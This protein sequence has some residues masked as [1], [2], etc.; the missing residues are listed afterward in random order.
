MRSRN[1]VPT[2]SGKKFNENNAY[3]LLQ[4]ISFPRLAG[5]SG[6]KKVR[7]I[8]TEELKQIGFKPAF[9]RFKCQ[10]F[11]N[12]QSAL[13]VISPYYKRYNCDVVGLSGNTPSEGISGN[14]AVINYFSHPV[15]KSIKDSI[16]FIFSPN[17]DLFGLMKRYKIK[18]YVR[19]S[20]PS[21]KP[22]VFTTREPHQ[23]IFGKIPAVSISYEDAI[24]IIHKGASKIRITSRQKMFRAD[25]SNISV[26]VKGSDIP[27]ERIIVFGHYDSVFNSCAAQDNGG[28]TVCVVELARYFKQHQPL[29]TITFILFGAEEMGLL[30]SFY[31]ADK[32]TGKDLSTIKLAINIDNVGPVFGDN[33]AVICGNESMQNYVQALAREIGLPMHISQ[34]AFSS[35]NIPLNERGIPSISLGRTVGSYGHSSV[36]DL[37]ITNADVVGIIGDFTIQLVERIANSVKIPFDL[38]IAEKDKELVTKYIEALNLK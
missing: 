2:I 21:V 15:I 10:T 38:K 14:P 3:S 18:G 11:D 25:V 36:N 17:K 6:D 32:L 29:R 20:P 22:I 4:R 9:Q 24:E 30:G 33:R 13:E 31:Y 27:E 16:P 12:T 19:V 35:D 5:T 34:F 1:G 8:L 37:K 23:K 7:G 28:G 26:E